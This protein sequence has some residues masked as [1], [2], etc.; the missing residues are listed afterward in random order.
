MGVRAGPARRGEKARERLDAFLTPTHTGATVAHDPQNKE[1]P[2]K[3]EVLKLAGDRVCPADVNTATGIR[4]QV[5]AEQPASGRTRAFPK[6][7]LSRANAG[8]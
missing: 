5:S 1:T 3:A 6:S 2:V 7:H 4:T 8:R